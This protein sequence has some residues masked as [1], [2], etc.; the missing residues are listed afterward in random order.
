M[1]K[2]LLCLLEGIQWLKWGI[3][4]NEGLL[5]GVLLVFY[6][7]HHLLHL[8]VLSDS[9]KNADPTEN[10]VQQQKGQ[11]E[12]HD[13]CLYSQI[14]FQHTHLLKMGKRNPRCVCIVVFV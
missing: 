7:L 2:P 14:S 5:F 9:L 11:T 3:L 4:V 13:D 1:K 12:Q 10:A 8:S 6:L